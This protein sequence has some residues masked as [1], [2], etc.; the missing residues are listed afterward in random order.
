LILTLRGPMLVKQIAVYQPSAA[1]KSRWDRVSYWDDK[2]PSAGLG[3]GFQGDGVDGIGF[4]GS[5]GN[6]CLVDVS[7]DRKFACGPGSVPYCPANSPSHRYGWEG[8]KLILLQASMPHFGATAL[9]GAKHCSTDKADNWFD[10]PW[11]GLS[12]GELIRA[13]KFDGCNCYAKDP[14][15]WWLA[16]G[17]GQFNVFETVND[18]GAFQNFDVFSTNFFAY[19]GYVGEGPCGKAC[20]VSKLDGTVDVID[21]AN[22]REAM[23]AVSTPQKGPG[24]AF[25]RPADGYRYFVMLLDAQTRTVQLAVVHPGNLP[26][27]MA[28][29]ATAAPAQLGRAAI[30]DLLAMRLP[31]QPATGLFRE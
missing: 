16:D 17:C 9:A 10:A 8:S 23:A 13:G 19:H 11:I 18:N 6:K 12:H 20:D 3:I 5:I 27:A 21:K 2:N 26:M 31:G 1:D 28:A 15:Q 30:Q 4:P 14:A 29:F 7:T 24:T 22:S 25:R